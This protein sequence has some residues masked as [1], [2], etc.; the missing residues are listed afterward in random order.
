[1]TKHIL[2]NLDEPQFAPSCDLTLLEI[3]RSGTFSWFTGAT[4]VTQERDGELLWW[5]APVGEVKKARS[6]ADIE[7]ALLAMSKL[8]LSLHTNQVTTKG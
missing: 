8:K 6:N 2:I 4:C 1:M 5:S 3:I 7:A